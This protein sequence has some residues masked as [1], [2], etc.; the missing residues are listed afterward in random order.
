MKET[1][2]NNVQIARQMDMAESSVRK[3]LK[4]KDQ[5]KKQGIL[6]AEYGAFQLTKVRSRAMLEMER[7][8]LIWIEDCGH[9][10][11]PISLQETTFKAVYLNHF[12]KNK[13][14]DLTEKEK[15]ETFTGSHGWWHRF[16]KR[17]SVA[18]INLLGQAGSADK[19]SA[20]EFP[21]ELKKII[22]GKRLKRS[23]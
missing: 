6:S 5:I 9:R 15:N 8:L 23:P 1:G 20:E 10:R 19:Q 4:D 17:V 18:S 16:S 12:V 14:D 3:I 7:L 21:N 13:I 11:I 22:D 2:A